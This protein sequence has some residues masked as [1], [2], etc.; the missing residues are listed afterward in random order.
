MKRNGAEN[1]NRT[2]PDKKQSSI[3]IKEIHLG[4]K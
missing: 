1:G 2:S 3:F 4:K